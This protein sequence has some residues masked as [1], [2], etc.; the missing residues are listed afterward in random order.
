MKKIIFLSLCGVLTLQAADH[1]L[2][3]HS[4]EAVGGFVL[5]SSDSKLD[6]NWNLGF[7]YNYNRDTYSPWDIAA[8]QFSFDYSGNTDYVNGNGS[9][10]V[11]RFGGNLMWYAD[12]ESDFTPFA[13]LGC[14]FQIFNNEK[15]GQS[16]GMFATVGGGIE[17]QLRG[18]VS[19]VTEGKW[20]YAGSKGD[21]ILG[22]FGIKYSFGN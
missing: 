12:N 8:F 2:Y 19:L 6:D 7:R 5:N 15:N 17:Y 10:N 20:D 22:N 1:A 13:I 3:N 14:G 9:T 18:D 4:V 21:Y 11:Y 16:N